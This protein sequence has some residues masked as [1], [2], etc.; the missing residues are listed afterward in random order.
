[1]LHQTVIV[2][3]GF[4]AIRLHASPYLKFALVR[5][6]CLAHAYSTSLFILPCPAHAARSD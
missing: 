3:I 5:K 6:L 4:Y 1:M 2:L